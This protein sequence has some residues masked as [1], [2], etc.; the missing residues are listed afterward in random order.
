[1]RNRWEFYYTAVGGSSCL[2]GYWGTAWCRRP[3]LHTHLGPFL[4]IP[5]IPAPQLTWVSAHWIHHPRHLL[6]PRWIQV[7][8]EKSTGSLLFIP[9]LSLLVCF[10]S[11]S[12]MSLRVGWIIYSKINMEVRLFLCVYK[13]YS[14]G[15]AAST[16]MTIM[17]KGANTNYSSHFTSLMNKIHQSSDVWC[18]IWSSV[19]EVLKCDAPQGQ[20]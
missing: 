5:T 17:Y 15:K 1:M 11:F 3:E 6:I 14:S 8:R 20:W 9:E 16:H 7:Q 12:S 18:F 10:S 4:V 13:C 19:H 2:A